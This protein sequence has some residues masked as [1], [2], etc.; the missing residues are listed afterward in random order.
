VHAERDR[1][2]SSGG[3]QRHTVDC[4]KLLFVSVESE[5]RSGLAGNVVVVMISPQS[6]RQLH[7]LD[8]NGDPLGVDG[9]QLRWSRV[10]GEEK[11]GSMIR[12]EHMAAAPSSGCAV[13][14]EGGADASQKMQHIATEEAPLPNNAP[15]HPQT[16]PP[17]RPRPLP[18]TPSPPAANG[19]Q[20]EQ[21]AQLRRWRALGQSSGWLERRVDAALP[22]PPFLAASAA[23]EVLIAVA[24]GSRQLPAHAEGRTAEWP[25][26]G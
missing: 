23:A 8:K 19:G 11:A 3:L 12:K 2:R 15:A 25:R 17:G 13:H 16:G 24:A 4:I 6:P 14:A 18:A 21:V 7:V 1:Q 20:G 5:V 9:T 10:Q 22:G 26:L